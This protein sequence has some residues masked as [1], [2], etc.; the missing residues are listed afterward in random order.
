MDKIVCEDN[1]IQ[2]FSSYDGLSEAAKIAQIQETLIL[3]WI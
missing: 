3:K 2:T 1:V